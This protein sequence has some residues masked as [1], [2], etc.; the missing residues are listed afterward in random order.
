MS[1][2]ES[3]LPLCPSLRQSSN[4]DSDVEGFD[5]T[6][7]GKPG[8]GKTIMIGHQESMAQRATEAETT[9]LLLIIMQ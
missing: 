8:G 3:R 9:V 7:S 4:G 2:P 6:V 1:P 5:Q